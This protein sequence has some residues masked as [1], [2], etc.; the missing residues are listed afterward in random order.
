MG[1]KERNTR[2]TEDMSLNSHGTE[3]LETSV[4]GQESYE[5]QRRTT[6][7]PLTCPPETWEETAGDNNPN[8]VGSAE[9][10]GSP[11]LQYSL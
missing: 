11:A 2:G 6:I 9:G 10:E 8:D 7:P 4:F 3:Y 5:E 1:A